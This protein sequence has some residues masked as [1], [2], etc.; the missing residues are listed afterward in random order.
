[1]VA[2]SGKVQSDEI[3]FGFGAN[4][5][6][7]L[8]WVNEERI[9]IATCSLASML[10]VSTLNGMRFLDVGSGSGLFSL[11]AQRMGAT[12]HSF[13]Y[14]PQSVAAT[15]ELRRRFAA[16]EPVW[17]IESGSILDDDYLAKLGQFDVVYSWGV[18]HHT[19]NMWRAIDNATSLVRDGGKLFISIYNHMG[20]AS[21]RWTRIKRTYCRLPPVLRLPF[22]LA[23]TTP[24]QLY[25]IGVYLFQGKLPAYV[26]KIRHYRTERGMNWWHDQ[27]DWIG[28][29]PYEDAKPEE[30]F[31]YVKRRGF[32]LEQLKTWGGASGC[33]EFLFMKRTV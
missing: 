15:T 20:G 10:G 28:G 24:I 8:E 11:A 23:V 2:A 17:T 29:Y 13:D 7:F 5:S 30:V 27:L 6:N 33:N 3:R 22:A 21:R 18:L 9:Q 31:V 4:W 16:G 25:S 12:V 32:S 1:M 14:D 26:A 19:G